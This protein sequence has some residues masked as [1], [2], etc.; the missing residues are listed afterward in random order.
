M[1]RPWFRLRAGADTYR[2]ATPAFLGLVLD[3]VTMMVFWL[4]IDCWQ[5]RTNHGLL[6][7]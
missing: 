5:G 7:G 2:R 1:P 6:P 4:L 3:G